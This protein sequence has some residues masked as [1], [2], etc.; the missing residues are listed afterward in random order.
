MGFIY[1]YLYDENN[2]VI[3]KVN[4]PVKF[5]FLDIGE[6]PVLAE[7]DIAT[8]LLTTNR[9]LF[10]RKSTM[11]ASSSVLQ[12]QEIRLVVDIDCDQTEHVYECIF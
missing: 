1:A 8:T 10:V 5:S 9:L 4:T 2:A 12:Q 6:N 3:P 11:M 7:A